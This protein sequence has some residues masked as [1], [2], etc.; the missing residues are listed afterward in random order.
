M[1]KK[2]IDVIH[3]ILGDSNFNIPRRA[4][5]KSY[6]VIKNCIEIEQDIAYT[7]WNID[8]RDVEDPKAKRTERCRDR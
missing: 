6:K 3:H 7:Y 1:S 5:L 4:N 2:Y 8:C